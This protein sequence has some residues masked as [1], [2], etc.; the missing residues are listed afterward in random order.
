MKPPDKLY[1]RN[2][3][4]SND[5]YQVADWGHEKD[6]EYINAQLIKVIYLK[7][8]NNIVIGNCEITSI[9]NCFEEIGKLV[10]MNKDD[11]IVFK[12]DPNQ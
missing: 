5:C 7:H 11:C 8:Y 9:E 3:L 12:C 6:T 2:G 4:D 1:L 10:G